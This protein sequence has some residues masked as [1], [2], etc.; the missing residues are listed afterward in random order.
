MHKVSIERHISQ[1]MS[2]PFPSPRC[3][4][5]HAHLSIHHEIHLS[6]P[7][8][9]P[10]PP[11][12]AS[13]TSLLW[14]LGPERMISLFH[15]VLTQQRICVHSLNLQELTPAVE[16]VA[17]LIFPLQWQ[18]PFIPLCPI[19]LGKYRLTVKLLN[20]RFIASVYYRVADSL[21]DGRF[22]HLL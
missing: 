11:S 20:Y 15:A 5:I 9:R 1:F 17:N 19:E 7:R 18:C 10:L 8:F 13:F 12:G 22:E 21:T 4:R 3:P 16:A 14:H 6:L 2:L